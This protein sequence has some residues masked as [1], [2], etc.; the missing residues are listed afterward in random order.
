[1]TFDTALFKNHSLKGSTLCQ[2]T[3]FNFRKNLE[4]G[5]MYILWINYWMVFAMEKNCDCCDV[6]KELLCISL[7]EIM[8]QSFKT[9]IA[10]RYFY[11]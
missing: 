5:S 3:V 8:L 11:V 2:W 7:S 4:I 9:S 10:V 1:M 6:G